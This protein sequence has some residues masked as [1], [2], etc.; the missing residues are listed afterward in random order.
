MWTCHSHAVSIAY[1]LALHRAGDHGLLAAGEGGFAGTPGVG[2]PCCACGRGRG[3]HT[4]RRAAA[5]ETAAPVLI[6]FSWRVVRYQR[7]GNAIKTQTTHSHVSEGGS[8]TYRADLGADRKYK[9]HRRLASCLEL[10]IKRL[11]VS[12]KFFTKRDPA[13]RRSLASG[14]RG[15]GGDTAL[16]P[17]PPRRPGMCGPGA[18][19]AS[20]RSQDVRL[21]LTSPRNVPFLPVH[22][23]RGARGHA[24]RVPG[25]HPSFPVPELDLL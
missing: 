7:G 16:R 3:Q 19:T 17:R 20:T 9:L 8:G 18:F 13:W 2:R 22:R 23:R 6:S 12:L 25:G 4:A 11:R 24:G 1:K 21:P 15:G 14:C 10:P 5:R